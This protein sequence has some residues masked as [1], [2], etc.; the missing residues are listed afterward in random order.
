MDR[1]PNLASLRT[2]ADLVHRVMPSTPALRW[3]LL[4]ERAAAEV[5]VKHENHSPVGAFK[6]RGGLVYFDELKRRE[7]SIT[8]VI[9]ATRGNHGQSVAY[10]ARL[11][12]LRAVIVVPHGN[13]REKNAAM[14]ALGAELIESGDDFQAAFEHAA[15][16]ASERSHHFVPSFDE[17]LVRGV[18]TAYLELFESVPGL[19]ALYVPIGL[20][21]GICGAMAARA[22]LNLTTEIVGVVSANAPAYAR[23]FQARQPIAAAVSPTIADGMACRV[24]DPRA[25]GHILAGVA[26]IVTV[27]EAEIRAAMRHL[28]TDTHNVAEGAGAASLAALLQERELRRGRRVA[29]VLTGGNVDAGIFAEVL[30]GNGESATVS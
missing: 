10:C 9:A 14:R 24:P 3:P 26:R 22:A 2:A 20:G 19:D 25:L 7:P 23:S 6:L 17:L 28:F 27:D 30:S 16:V 29:V 4:C 8:G 11:H 21:S 13:S 15:H 18:A 1:L 12:G 5:W